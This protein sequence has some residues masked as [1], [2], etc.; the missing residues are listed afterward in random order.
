VHSKVE[1]VM[2]IIDDRTIDFKCTTCG[3][4]I[5]ERVGWLKFQ[6]SVACPHCG[7][8]INLD[9]KNLAREAEQAQEAIDRLKDDFR[10]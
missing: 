10:R 9:T 5:R 1:V 8:T 2:G 7:A 4:E 3:H 6:D